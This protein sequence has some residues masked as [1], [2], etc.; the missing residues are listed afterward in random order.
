M[1][2]VTHAGF[3]P[4]SPDRIHCTPEGLARVMTAHPDLTLV[5]AHMG[6]IGQIDG[7][8]DMLV[9]SKIF[10]D[11][12]LSSIRPDE[13]ERL[14]EILHL[15]D[16]GR[17]LFG[18]DTPWSDPREEISFLKESGLSERALDNIFYKNAARLLRPDTEDV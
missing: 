6:G 13:R 11:T 17:I 5:A 9:G 12:S 18:T 2:V 8:F 7:V 16:D 3:D 15:H 4:V 14:Y 1:Y 10:L